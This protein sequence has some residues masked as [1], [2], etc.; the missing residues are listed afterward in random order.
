MVA[1]VA[2]TC[3]PPVRSETGGEA[4]LWRPMSDVTVGRYAALTL[5]RSTSNICG[6]SRCTA[7]SRLF[8]S[9]ILTASSN[10]SDSSSPGAG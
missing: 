3:A 6:S 9:A 5:A 7:M 10:D 8:S 4:W 1:V 2:V